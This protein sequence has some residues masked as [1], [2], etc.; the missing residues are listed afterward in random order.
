MQCQ[1]IFVNL[2]VVTFRYKHGETKGLIEEVLIVH[3]L[4]TRVVNLH[5]SYGSITIIMSSVQF[6]IT[7]HHGELTMQYS[8]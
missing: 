7:R 6:D 1:I 4:M 2:Y 3:S 8:Y 5:W